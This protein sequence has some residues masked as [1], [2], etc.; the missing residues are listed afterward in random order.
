MNH[1][2]SATF[3]AA[4]I[5]ITLSRPVVANESVSIPLTVP[6]NTTCGGAI[7]GVKADLAKRKFFIPWTS[8]RPWLKDIQPKVE[9]NDQS[10]QETYF[11][12][13]SARTRTVRFFLSGNSQKLYNGFFSSPRL[14]TT[15]AAGIISA[16]DK[17]GLVEYVH[18]YEGYTPVGYF[19]DNTV[20]KFTYTDS[21][22]RDTPYTRTI[23]VNGGKMTKRMFE[24]GYFYSL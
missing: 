6:A 15:L 22:R 13:P 16:C 12:Y 18:W 23:P 7:D 24:W 14:M 20:R 1:R 8:P 9:I 11:N 5:F 10:V 19:S 2:P 3:L 21:G 4:V 17:V